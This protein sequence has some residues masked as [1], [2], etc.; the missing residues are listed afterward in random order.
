MDGL[1]IKNPQLIRFE[2]NLLF[3]DIDMS[4][5]R[6]QRRELSRVGHCRAAGLSMVNV[7]KYSKWVWEDRGGKRALSHFTLLGRKGQV[8]EVQFLFFCLREIKIGLEY[9]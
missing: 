5:V 8:S 2:I 6:L 3:E 7:S 1:K 9:E 4:Q